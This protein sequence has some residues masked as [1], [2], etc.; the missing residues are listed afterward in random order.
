MADIRFYHVQKRRPEDELPGLLHRIRRK[1][2]KVYIQTPDKGMAQQLDKFLWCYDEADFLPHGLN[3]GTNAARH[4]ISI[5]A[6]GNP[7]N[8]ADVI[9]FMPGAFEAELNAYT[10]GCLLIDGRDTDKTVQAREIWKELKARGHSLTYW[11]QSDRGKWEQ[12]A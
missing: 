12:K 4:P 5:G 9:I 3:N 10:I 2:H 1:G 11:Q 8:D 7:A 6:D